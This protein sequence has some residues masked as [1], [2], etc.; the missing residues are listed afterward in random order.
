[1]HIQ[2]EITVTLTQWEREALKY[3]V[4]CTLNNPEQQIYQHERES[5][6]KLLDKISTGV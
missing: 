3:V 4:N 2:E 5:L 6:K 1:M